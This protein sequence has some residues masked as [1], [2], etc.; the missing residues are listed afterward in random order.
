MH[1]LPTEYLDGY[2]FRDG[3]LAF[4][5]RDAKG[6]ERLRELGGQMLTSYGQPG[7]SWA[8]QVFSVLRKWGVNTYLDAHEIFNIDGQPFWYGGVL[9]FTGLNNLSHLKKD[10]SIGEMIRAF[11]N[12]DTT[13][14][15]TVFFSIYDHPTEFSSSEFWD[16]C[17]FAK[18]RNPFVYRSVPL[19]TVEERDA[20]IN[21][22]R[23]FIN[24]TSVR[25]GM[26]YVTASEAMRYERQ[27]MSPISTD[28]LKSTVGFCHSE[29][30]FVKIGPSWLAPSEMLNLMARYLTGRVLTPELL[31]G[32]EKEETSVSSK[33]VKVRELAEAV[34]AVHDRVMGYKQLPSLYRIGDQF[35]NP[36]DAFCTLANAINTGETEMM[37]T[38][39]RFAAADYVND[40]FKFGG[41]WVLWDDTFKA[42][43]IVNQTKR[44][45]WTLKPAVF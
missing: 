25:P 13:C 29:A 31:Y 20:L 4:E 6:F 33:P 16:E 38:R 28:D 45:T 5:T 21:Q 27:R 22:Y 9:C 24:N 39:A 40:K 3:S 41:N 10:G 42:E 14:E 12:M 23:E 1:P 11:D 2:G 32:P 44:Q 37:I 34:F 36:A 35:I 26:E 30:S 15:E 8:P 19:R 43:N 17:N 7:E 18:G